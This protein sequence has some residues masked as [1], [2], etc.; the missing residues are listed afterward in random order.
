MQVRAAA[1][2]ALPRHQAPVYQSLGPASHHH[3]FSRSRTTHYFS[4]TSKPG[5]RCSCTCNLEPANRQ[6]Y[7][8]RIRTG[9]LSFGTT[10]PPFSSTPNTSS[11]LDNTR[12]RTQLHQLR[13]RLL[14]HRPKHSSRPRRR[15]HR[16]RA[17]CTNRTAKLP[18]KSIT[19]A[20][21][22]YICASTTQTSANTPPSGETMRR[23][24]LQLCSSSPLVTLSAR[25][26]E[27]GQRTASR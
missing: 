21:G 15:F 13:V 25:L 26:G 6:R 17:R 5:M 19:R 8:R 23:R 16:S 18:H 11:S 22:H 27:G 2:T 12:H 24:S 20:C 3:I 9:Y 7:M 10:T 14:H 4:S 1:C